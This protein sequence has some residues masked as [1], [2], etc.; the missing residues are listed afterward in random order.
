M[1]LWLLNCRTEVQE[2]I[3]SGGNTTLMI[4]VFFTLFIFCCLS[5]FLL[6][7]GRF[8]LRMVTKSASVLFLNLSM[9]LTGVIFRS[10]LT[11]AI[12]AYLSSGPESIYLFKFY[13]IVMSFSDFSFCPQRAVDAR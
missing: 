1:T 12:I 8:L 6:L 5:T 11:L 10:L 7:Y 13:S 2:V 4:E 9:M 3:Y